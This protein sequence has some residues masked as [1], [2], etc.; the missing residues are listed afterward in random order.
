MVEPL[1]NGVHL[2]NL[3][4]RHQFGSLAIFGAGTQGIL[5]L[6][7]ARLLGYRRIAVVDT[8]PARLEVAR[9]FGAEMRLNPAE[10]EAPAAICDWTGGLGADIGIDAAGVTAVRRALVHT[11]RKGCE[12]MLL[13][14]HDNTSD[15]DF[16]LV[17][18][19][20]LRLQGSYAYT[21]ADFQTSKRLIEDG[22]IDI[23]PWTRTRPLEEGQSAFDLLTT[24]PGD[25]LKIVLTP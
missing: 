24:D 9:K 4:R 1:A 3:I 12:V 17:V 21:P 23:Q 20:E 15:L 2:F 7:L 8:N 11:V 16:S 13:G 10:T 14:L 25:V 22:D 6:A 19:K 18:R 5:M